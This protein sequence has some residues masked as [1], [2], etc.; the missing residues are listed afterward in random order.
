V[1]EIDLRAP[2][3]LHGRK[4]FSRLEW[5]C[6]N[7]LNK[8]LTWLFCNLN[9]SSA[10]SLREGKEPI[11]IHQPFIHNIDPVITAIPGVTVPKLNLSDLTGLYDQEDAL[12]LQE[13]IHLLSLS[14]PRLSA[15]D[16]IDPH[17][18]RYEVPT[19]DMNVKLE[20]RNMVR[21]RW[22]GFMGPRFVRDLFLMVRREGLRTE[23]GDESEES[24]TKRGL[25]ERWV[26]WNAEAFGGGR[27]WTIMQW[28][29]RETLVWEC[30]I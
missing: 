29:G 16:S 30:E 6:K 19:F 3:M 12:A 4:G 15:N 22:R 5:A 27:G 2:S 11:S 17:L 24:G 9:S 21:V 25:E 14:S 10:E 8:S 26:G 23:K 13:Y 18:S 20:T 7:V 28:A 1:I